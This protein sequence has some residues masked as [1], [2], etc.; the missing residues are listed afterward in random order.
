M[1]HMSHAAIKAHGPSAL[2][3]II[4]DQSDM[5][6]PSIC[7]GCETGKSTQKPFPGSTKKSDQI[8]QIIHSDL[9]GPMQTKSLQGSQYIATFIDDYSHHAVVYYLKSKD[10]FAGA[11]HN[12]LSWAETQTDK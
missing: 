10:Q 6:V 2:K 5:A 1:G 3:G 11:L 4:L 12:F 8:L 7:T 9:A